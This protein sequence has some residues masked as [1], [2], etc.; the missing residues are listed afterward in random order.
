MN[1]KNRMP[2]LRM[3][4]W[5]LSQHRHPAHHFAR[6]DLANKA[7]HISEPHQN[8]NS[9]ART[10]RPEQPPLR[11][12]PY[13]TLRMKLGPS[14]GKV[15]SKPSPRAEASNRS[16]NSYLEWH[17]LGLETLIPGICGK[18]SI[19]PDSLPIPFLMAHPR[20]KP[21]PSWGPERGLVRLDAC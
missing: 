14:L 4:F 8:R 20:P 16:V 3:I 17:V 12:T 9:A 2:N 13:Q 11:A 7:I 10:N 1:P 21:D 19:H 18:A 5:A 6:Q 15:S